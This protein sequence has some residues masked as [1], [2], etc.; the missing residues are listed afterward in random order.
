MH[1]NLTIEEINILL[2][3]VESWE[4]EPLI[5]G[6][7]EMMLSGIMAT[8]SDDESS[9]NNATKQ[10]HDV[11]VKAEKETDDRKEIATLL[12]AKLYSMRKKLQTNINKLNTDMIGE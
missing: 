8:M 10:M 11:R 1:N 9:K 3:A 7:Q 12:K 6:G 5:M 2:N 4:K